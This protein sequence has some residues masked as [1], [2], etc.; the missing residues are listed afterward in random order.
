MINHY[1]LSFKNNEEGWGF[2]NFLA[3]KKAGACKGVGGLSGDFR[4]VKKEKLDDCLI[5]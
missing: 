2:N 1:S 4:R 5:G 3:L